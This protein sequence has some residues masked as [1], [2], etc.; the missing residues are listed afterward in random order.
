MSIPIF[1]RAGKVAVNK[2][3]TLVNDLAE[4]VVLTNRKIA[5][6]KDISVGVALEDP[7][8][9]AFVDPVLMKTALVGVLENAIKFSGKGASVSLHGKD[10]GENIVFEVADKGPGLA[11]DTLAAALEPFRQG[12]GSLQRRFEGMGLGLP[13]ARKLAILHGGRLEVVSEIGKGTIVSFILPKG[14]VPG[15]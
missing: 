12:D 3:A 11:E 9:L 13:L 5:E 6:E 2:Q 14:V 1:L 7:G 4:S 8:L 10:D 15:A